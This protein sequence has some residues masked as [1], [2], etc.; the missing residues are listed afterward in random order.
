MWT[1]MWLDFSVLTS[2]K[3]SVLLQILP[4]W[5]MD[6]VITSEGA[7]PPLTVY[8]FTPFFT[9]LSIIWIPWCWC[10]INIISANTLELYQAVGGNNKSWQLT[11]VFLIPCEQL[12]FCCASQSCIC[13][14]LIYLFISVQWDSESLIFQKIFLGTFKEAELMMTILGLVCGCCWDPL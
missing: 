12:F 9:F 8:L 4:E 14:I 10:L 13:H 5:R 3:L 2:I 6:L 7:S 1:I 11:S